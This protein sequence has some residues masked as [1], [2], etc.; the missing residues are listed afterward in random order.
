MNM[1]TYTKDG[2]DAL[3]GHKSNPNRNDLFKDIDANV[4]VS[5][6]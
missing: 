2:T 3:V 4:I 1:P 5:R 6:N